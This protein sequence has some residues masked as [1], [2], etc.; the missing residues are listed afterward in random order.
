MSKTSQGQPAHG[1]WVYLHLFLFQVSLGLVWRIQTF[2][3]W[4][5]G[6]ILPV[7][8]L[9][10]TSK[11]RF[12]SYKNYLGLRKIHQENS[13]QQTQ[14]YYMIMVTHHWFIMKVSH[15]FSF[16]VEFGVVH[17]YRLSGV[18]HTVVVFPRSTE[19]V[20]KIVKIAIRYRM[21][22]IPYSGAT[23]LEG[24]TRG[25]SWCNQLSIAPNLTTFELTVSSW[26]HMYW[27]VKHEQDSGDSWY[28]VLQSPS[29]VQYDVAY[30]GRLRFGVSAW[31]KV[32]WHQ[33]SSARPR[34]VFRRG[35][36]SVIL[37]SSTNVRDSLVF[38]CACVGFFISLSQS[39]LF[40]YQICLKLDPAPEATI[41]GMLSTGCS[42]SMSNSL[43]SAVAHWL[44]VANAVR[45]G[46]AK[47][48]WFLNAASL[49]IQLSPCQIEFNI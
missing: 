34:F 46:T 11:R 8:D 16:V 38:P 12:K 3:I 25:V 42:G 37:L 41:G 1:V 33:R 13:L 22:I 6:K 19:D 15:T 17:V 40:C 4:I 7:M 47:A 5:L 36:Y 2:S 24:Q 20:T 23:S 27:Y 44:P 14:T 48:E 21:P 35:T 39:D 45:Y 32:G 18:A 10:K 9:Q 43:W 28:P 26:R 30:R 29:I 49:Q 31:H